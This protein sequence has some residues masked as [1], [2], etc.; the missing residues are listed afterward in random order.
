MTTGR[1][2]RKRSV[3]RRNA[4]VEAYNA[5]SL[6]AAKAYGLEINDLYTPLVDAGVRNVLLGDGV[7]LNTR[8]SQILGEKV[9]HAILDG[10]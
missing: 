7:H 9:A 8:G 10:L 2:G 6:E 5:A 3:G 1:R 4:D